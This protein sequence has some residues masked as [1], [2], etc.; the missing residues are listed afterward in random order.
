MQLRT[1]SKRSVLTNVAINIKSSEKRQELLI[2]L[3]IVAVLDY[4]RM[5][6]V[7]AFRCHSTTSNQEWN[8]EQLIQH[9]T[10]IAT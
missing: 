2:G 10:A 3:K 8:V 4:R 9:A 1:N 5:D 6:G 7:Q